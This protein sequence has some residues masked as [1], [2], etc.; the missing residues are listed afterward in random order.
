MHDVAEKKTETP[1]PNF[2]LRGRNDTNRIGAGISG[3]LPRGYP[4]GCAEEAS[5]PST[6]KPIEVLRRRH[7]AIEQA[8]RVTS[9]TFFVFSDD[10][11]YGHPGQRVLYNSSQQ[12][13]AEAP[14]DAKAMV[15]ALNA[16]IA[17]A[18]A[19]ETRRHN[20]AADDLIADAAKVFAALRG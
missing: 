8:H 9:R 20:A 3:G 6:E 4:D 13:I 5:G 11:Y 18:K 2:Q 7:D 10:I 12:F 1:N 16:A 19:A 17:P 15:D 14:L